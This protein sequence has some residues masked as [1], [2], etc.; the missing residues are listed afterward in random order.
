LA[1]LAQVPISTWNY[2]AEDASIRHIGPTAQDFHAAFGLGYNDTSISTVDADGVALAAAQGLYDL[3]QEQAARIQQL[4]A[5][6]TDLQTQ[7]DAQQAQLDTQ[8]AQIDA[9]GARLAALEGS[10]PASSRPASGLLWPGAGIALAGV[11]V[12]LFVRRRGGTG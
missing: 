5:E 8:Q 2:R 7:L 9:L 1:R 10:S 6:N 12:A 3:S 4:E 11:T